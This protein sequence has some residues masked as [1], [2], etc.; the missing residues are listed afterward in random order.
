MYSNFMGFSF[1]APPFEESSV[2]DGEGEL[3]GDT[4]SRRSPGFSSAGV[5]D[6]LSQ[7]D[8]MA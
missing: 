8:P 4:A 7:T 3:G 5:V 6:P 1:S 2:T